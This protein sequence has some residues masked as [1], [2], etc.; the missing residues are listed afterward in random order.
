MENSQAIIFYEISLNTLRVRW[1]RLPG[2]C[3]RPILPVL[4]E[5]I[6]TVWKEPSP[7]NI[8]S[9][10]LFSL[11]ENQ[12]EK[13]SIWHRKLWYCKW[14]LEQRSCILAESIR[15]NTHTGRRGGESLLMFCVIFLVSPLCLVTVF[16]QRECVRTTW[17]WTQERMEVYLRN[18]NVSPIEKAVH[19]LSNIINLLITSL[20]EYFWILFWCFYL[21]RVPLSTKKIEKRVNKGKSYL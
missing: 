17:V 19:T 8:V 14:Q 12:C 21:R 2:Q 13:I 3:R 16:N 4:S 7:L 10:A 11:S 9:F 6:N 15:K 20:L 5:D 18:I 1:Y